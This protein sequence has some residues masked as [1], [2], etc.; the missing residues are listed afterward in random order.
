[1]LV[2]FWGVRGSIASPGKNTARYGGNTSCIEVRSDSGQV[3]ILDAGTGIRELGNDL[4]GRGLPIHVTLLVSHTHWDHIQGFPFFVPAYVPG[5]R[6][7]IFGPVHFD[8]DQGRTLK[9]VF[10]M[11]MDYAYFPVS[12]A[13][14]NA[15]LNFQNLKDEP[16]QIG[17]FRVSP[18]Y[19]NHPITML[20]YRIECDGKTVAYTGDNEPYYDTI[21]GGVDPE[22]L[23][24]DELADYE[25]VR[26]EVAEANAAIVAFARDADLLVADCQYTDEEYPSKVGW[27]HSYTS[28]VEQLAIDA[29]VGQL[30]MFHHDPM[31]SDDELEEIENKVRQSLRDRTDGRI[32]GFAA[33]E[34]LE[35][36][37]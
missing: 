20:G 19:L 13:Q 17:D 18:Q 24:E 23:D 32:K 25:D 35:V 10:D 27:G 16:V 21:Y 12:T 11:Q 26:R 29:N 28:F 2:K 9:S 1:M 6:V 36:K 7:D 15:E 34:G 33:A 8:V 3:L 14:L 5:N 37:L 31:R 4:M 22:E 30:A